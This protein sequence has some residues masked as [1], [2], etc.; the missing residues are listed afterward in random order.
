M[1][2]LELIKIF[3]A[4]PGDVL[5]ER[6]YADEVVNEINKSFAHD[7]G[8]M[9]KLVSSKDLIP[10][11]GR[12]GQAIV[13]DQVANMH[14]YD[15]F[16]CLMWYRIGTPT[17]RAQSG[18]VEEFRRAESAKKKDGKPDIWFYFRN[19]R[20]KLK[21]DQDR[22]QRAK[23]M[24]FKKRLR[25]NCIYREYDAPKDFRDNFRTHLM[26]WLTKRKKVIDQT[27]SLPKLSIPRK[28]TRKGSSRGKITSPGNLIKLDSH[29]YR[30]SVSALPDNT[31]QLIVSNVNRAQVIQLNSL[32]ST[33]NYPRK[34]VA[35]ADRHTAGIFDISAVSSKSTGSTTQFTINL[36]PLN[37]SHN[38]WIPGLSIS[39]YSP[40]KIAEFQARLLLLG[41]PLP[42][43]L[44][45]F[46]NI[47]YPDP[48]GNYKNLSQAI[49]PELWAEQTLKRHDFFLPRAWLTAMYYLK[50][51]NVIDNILR[52]QLGP[53]N[54]NS[55]PV[56]FEGNRKNPYAG[57]S[58]ITITVKGTCR[59]TD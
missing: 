2:Q 41:E 35:F 33:W 57:G 8:F 50:V 27:Q 31:I 48:K 53:I 1:A 13:N 45:G 3:L 30:A 32:K 17:P 4:S 16:V 55:L 37:Q 52:L 18:T 6:Q 19:A 29:F 46:A 14:E 38:R 10:E 25:S 34:S 23:V 7:N 26:K 12:D 49:F 47:Q 54:N 40:D 15:L 9:L 42:R 21:N 22:S 44:N 56:Q 5:S 11:Y 24:A 58:P 39:G 59:L 43:E 28:K 20:K 36:S 51:T